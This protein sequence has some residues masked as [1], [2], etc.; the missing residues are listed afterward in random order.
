MATEVIMPKM[1]MTMEEGTVLQW[2]KQEGDQVEKGQP[3]LEIETDKVDVEVEAPASGILRGVLAKANDVVPATQ[4]I[5]HILAPGEALPGAPV[6]PAPERPSQVEQ[7]PISAVQAQRSD[8]SVA[9]SPMAKRLAREAGLELR[10]IRGTGPGKSIVAA[11]VEAAVAARVLP[12]APPPPPVIAAVISPAPSAALQPKPAGDG[13]LVPLTGK[14]KVIAQ[15]MAVSATVPQFALGMN[16]DMTRA[17]E[18][19]AE[20]SPT[21]LLVRVVAHA[22]RNHV[23]LNASFTDNGIQMHEDINVGV[24]V[25]VEDG[26]VVPVVKSADTKSLPLLDAQIKDLAERA[27]SGKLQLDEMTGGTFTI[28]NLGM[29]GVEEFKAL[30]NPPEAAI[31]AVGRIMPQPVAA[32]GQIVLRPMLHLVLSADHRVVDGAMAA[33]FLAEVKALLEKP[34]MLL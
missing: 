1:G 16:V 21:A 12:I 10:S 22:L 9:A 20:Y 18:A 26:L 24:A 15:R 34:Y 33:V 27:R 4:V 14:R 25:N 32:D 23:M 31:L 5:A 17:E 19:R 7:P 2:F 6:A 13:K 30:I 3:L 11:D 28:S 29:F 8:G